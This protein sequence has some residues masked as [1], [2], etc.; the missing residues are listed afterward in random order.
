[1]KGIKGVSA[2]RINQ[3]LGRNGPLWQDEAFDHVVRNFEST[4]AKLDGEREPPTAHRHE[5]ANLQ[6]RK[7]TRGVHP[8]R[9]IWLGAAI[10]SLEAVW[11][12]RPF[13]QCSNRTRGRRQEAEFAPESLVACGRGTTLRS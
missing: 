6:A 11:T 8:I 13:Y 1:M 3:L 5:V 10:L 9:F 4:Q 12:S 7:R 2:R